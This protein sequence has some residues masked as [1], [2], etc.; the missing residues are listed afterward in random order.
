MSKEQALLALCRFGMGAA[1]GE[2]A[3]M[4]S[5]PRGWVIAQLDAQSSVSAEISGFDSA[6]RLL[7]RLAE[8]KRERKDDKDAGKGELRRAFIAEAAARTRAAAA[9]QAPFV[10][11][12]VRFWS[13][14]FTV[15]TKRAQI[16]PAVGAF[17]R[18]AIRPH[19]TGR[20][21]DMLRAVARHPVMLG[22][23]DNA[24][25]I[26]PNSVAGQKRSRGLN[27]NLARE[28]LELHTLGVDGGYDQGDV[29]SL[30][31]ILT[32][33]TVD[34]ARGEFRFVARMHEPG[35]K[36]LLGRSFDGGEGEGEEALAMLSRHPST[37]RFIAVKLAR[38][39]AGD[40]PPAS[41]VDALAGTFIQSDGDLKEL[42]RVLAL[43]GEP[44]AKPLAKI[45][46]PDDLV[47]ATLKAL[48]DW[49][50]NEEGDRR[51]VQ[52]L[53]ILGQ[54]P[55]GAASPAG[56]SDRA[57]AWI[58]PEALMLRLEWARAVSGRMA[59]R[60]GGTAAVADQVIM[61]GPRTRQAM[62]DAKGADSLFLLL[63]SREFQRR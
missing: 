51:L 36:H 42:S 14:H 57:E 26:G 58:A 19:V 18:E 8:L 30:A 25:S 1:P 29:E 48:G 53:A 24:Q 7:T 34:P 6:A 12:L 52:S 47:V 56:W 54:P 11:R 2:A 44:W 55:W 46:S 62:T 60:V 5:D 13:N 9:S 61:A 39:F 43:R 35:R 31:R 40:E 4:A 33:W 50:R 32:G 63:A 3:V 23:L 20:F 17:E 45:R 10:E 37:A 16:A 22:Y 21:L 28:M 49:E 27:E 15:S 59:R 38:H 41:L